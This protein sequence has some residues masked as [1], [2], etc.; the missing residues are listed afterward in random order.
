MCFWN[1]QQRILTW[2]SFTETQRSTPWNYS[3]G[4]SISDSERTSMPPNI[5]FKLV[6]RIKNMLTIKAIIVDKFL[7]CEWLFIIFRLKLFQV[8]GNVVHSFNTSGKSSLI[9][10]YND[11]LMKINNQTYSIVTYTVHF[12]DLVSIFL[13]VE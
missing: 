9:R 11:Q 13:L 6:S 1:P 3:Y 5:F 4:F 8:L 10:A 12:G 7:F 2:L